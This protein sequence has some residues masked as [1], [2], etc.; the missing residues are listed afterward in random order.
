MD[1]QM[2]FTVDLH[3]GDII[4]EWEVSM[5]IGQSKSDP[6]G[7][8]VNAGQTVST[9]QVRFLNHDLVRFS[10]LKSLFA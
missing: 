9:S 3:M 7:V 8:P 2:S 10:K 4:G 5:T 6:V 1:Q